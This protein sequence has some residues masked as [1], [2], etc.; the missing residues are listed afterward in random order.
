MNGKELNF[1]DFEDTLG[2]GNRIIV[3]NLDDSWNPGKDSELD[4]R[5]IYMNHCS[6]LGIDPTFEFIFAL[7]DR[8]IKSCILSNRKK[9]LTD[10][11]MVCIATALTT[12]KHITELD[13]SDNNITE[14]SS[15]CLGDMLK[16][17]TV[18]QKVVCG[19]NK[20]GDEGISYL[21]QCI[22]GNPFSTIIHLDVRGNKIINSLSSLSSVF[23]TNRIHTLNLQ[24][25]LIDESGASLLAS[26]L[27]NNSS[28]KV[29]NLQHN[30]I[31]DKGA[32]HFGKMLASNFSLQE[33]DVGS[34][35]IGIEGVSSLVTGLKNNKSL[36]KLNLRSNN[37]GDP[38]AYMFAKSLSLNTNALEE[39]YLGFNGVSVDGAIALANMLKSNNRLKKFDI[40]GIM[41]DL[42]AM[43][44]ISESLKENSSLL[45]LYLDIDSDSTKLAPQVAKTISEALQSN[46]TLQDL[47]IGG[48]MDFEEAFNPRSSI[49]HSSPAQLSPRRIKDN[50]MTQSMVT[51]TEIHSSVE[52]SPRMHYGHNSKSFKGMFDDVLEDGDISDFESETDHVKMPQRSPAKRNE[53]NSH[54]HEFD[55]MKYQ[56]LN[57]DRFERLEQLVFSIQKETRDSLSKLSAQVRDEIDGVRSFALN[58]VDSSL[59]S[60]HKNFESILEQ[61]G[62]RLNHSPLTHLNNVSVNSSGISDKMVVMNVSSNTAA[63]ESSAFLEQL[64]AELETKIE[65]VLRDM[66]ERLNGRISDVDYRFNQ[67]IATLHKSVDDKLERQQKV[68]GRMTEEQ[69]WIEEEG[70][71]LRVEHE[72]KVENMIKTL[73]TELEQMVEE[74]KNQNKETK[75]G[76][77]E[78]TSSLEKRIEELQRKVNEDV[79]KLGSQSQ[80]KDTRS[81]KLT[82]SPTSSSGKRDSPKTSSSDSASAQINL[83]QAL[84][85]KSKEVLD[86][87]NIQ[88]NK[89]IGDSR[90]GRPST[91]AEREY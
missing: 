81:T 40:Q 91:P 45:K 11:D 10:K 21:F 68:I 1:N 13:I 76:L 67:S 82:L 48:D 3:D 57:E 59:K 60:Y 55:S 64:K 46:N 53:H 2:I 14:E 36:L 49:P 6:K 17:N 89:T 63:R 84:L 72:A 23:T 33:L 61:Y 12:N 22:G 38:G 66:E 90:H 56:K 86:R 70:I 58:I 88:P 54:A 16:R 5:E 15:V 29:L 18:L 30:R 20:L 4:P 85:S 28:L 43:K 7:N 79:T 44:I 71:K 35:R 31:G 77:Y 51:K 83:I 62:T 8:N 19:N 9:L 52:S 78:R 24:N 32:T 65:N 87:Q 27:L 74:T 25:N 75:S 47:I 34:N 69:R 26:S 80:A 73:K 50:H 39:L 37:I 41:L 42:S